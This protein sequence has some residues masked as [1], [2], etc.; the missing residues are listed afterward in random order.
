MDP[1]RRPS[2]SSLF[3]AECPVVDRSRAT[4]NLT[5]VFLALSPSGLAE[6]LRMAADKDA[7]VWCGSDAISE[8]EFEACEFKRLTR[9]SYPLHDAS[10][11]VVSGAIETIEEHHPSERVW[12]E[13]K[14]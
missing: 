12:V 3:N 5:M 6:A 7:A 14:S 9:F 4:L 8:E 2:W 13:G 11:E 1:Q 10:S